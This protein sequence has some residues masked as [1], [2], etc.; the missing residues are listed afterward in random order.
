MQNDSIQLN[1]FSTVLFVYK[2]TR[3]LDVQGTFLL[4]R[5]PYDEEK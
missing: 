5:R 3:V 4:L 2:D 1:S